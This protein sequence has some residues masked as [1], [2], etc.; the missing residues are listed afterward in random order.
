[1]SACPCLIFSRFMSLS[2]SPLFLGIAAQTQNVLAAFLKPGIPTLNRTLTAGV[3][4]ITATGRQSPGAL[5]AS[6]ITLLGNLYLGNIQDICSSHPLLP[7]A[8]L[9]MVFR[10]RALFG[11]SALT[12]LHIAVSETRLSCGTFP[13]PANTSVCQQ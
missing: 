7:A 10:Q 4:Q 3:A 2:P 9:L 12:C 5:Q 8:G 13:D 11:V 1:M 6:A